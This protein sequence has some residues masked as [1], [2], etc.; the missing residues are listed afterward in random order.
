MT[1]E[2]LLEELQRYIGYRVRVKSE[3]VHQKWTELQDVKLL[4]S[5]VWCYSKDGLGWLVSSDGLEI[6]V[7]AIE[8]GYDDE[9]LP[10][11]LAA[12][13]ET[14]EAY[15][16]TH[17]EQHQWC[18]CKTCQARHDVEETEIKQRLQELTGNVI[19]EEPP[20]KGKEG[21]EG[22]ESMFGGF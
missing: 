21:T 1:D 19:D 13:A 8:G 12:I 5:G 11:R 6:E 18:H 14:I 22:P 7:K 16:Y 17:T 9:P 2:E 15:G 4:S 20:A 10:L 3:A